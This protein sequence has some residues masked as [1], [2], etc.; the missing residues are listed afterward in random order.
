MF[1]SIV[2]NVYTFSDCCVLDF[3]LLG[4]LAGPSALGLVLGWRERFARRKPYATLLV[5]CA[6]GGWIAD[7]PMNNQFMRFNVLL[8][9]AF[10]TTTDTLIRVAWKPSV[11]RK[12]RSGAGGSL[13]SMGNHTVSK[14]TVETRSYAMLNLPAKH[15]EAQQWHD[16]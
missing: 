1:T 13:A 11:G 6:F 10:A 7:V 15:Q 12:E 14:G 8:T 9:F 16:R 3:G 2:T 5:S 4:A